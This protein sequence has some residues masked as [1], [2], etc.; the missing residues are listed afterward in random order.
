MKTF[1][2]ISIQIEGLHQWKDAFEKA[3]TVGFLQH[4]HR[5]Q[6]YIKVKRLVS[7]A[8]RDVEIILFKRFIIDYLK[9]KYYSKTYDCLM[10]NNMSCEM[11]ATEILN[12]FGCQS[13]EVLEDA[14]NGAIV[15]I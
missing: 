4:L 15:E 9:K 2:V 12:E 8:D 5:H 6:F 10:F 11:I 7:H 13:V 3:Q 1:V 14:E